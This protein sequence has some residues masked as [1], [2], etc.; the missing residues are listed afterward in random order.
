M[1]TKKP[2]SVVYTEKNGYNANLLPYA[3][4]VGAPAIR[5]D[6][7]VSWKSRG[8]TNVNKEFEHKFDEL[9]LQDRKSTL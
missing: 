7:I 8:I 3:T 9:K 4:T 6:D 1:N 5:V 2:D